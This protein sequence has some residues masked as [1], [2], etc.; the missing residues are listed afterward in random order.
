[1]WR[2]RGAGPTRDRRHG[3]SRD[4]RPPATA[5]GRPA[6][7]VFIRTR[8]CRC[9]VGRSGGHPGFSGGRPGGHV[10]RGRDRQTSLFLLLPPSTTSVDG[11]Q[12]GVS[13]REVPTV[14]DYEGRGVYRF[15]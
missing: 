6:R 9:E 1:M 7:G 2:K 3:R 13:R 11:P 12:Y 8:H 4:R 10:S 14:R 15:F 5:V